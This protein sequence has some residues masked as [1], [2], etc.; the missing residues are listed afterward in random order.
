MIVPKARADQ[1]ANGAYINQE[2]PKAVGGIQYANEHVIPGKGARDP[3]GTRLYRFINV[4]GTGG[5]RRAGTPDE[6]ANGAWY[7][8]FE[9]FQKMKVYAERYDYP[10]GYAARLFAAVL[11][12]WSDVDCYVVSE[13]ISPKPIFAWKGRGRQIVAADLNDPNARPR[14]VRDQ[15]KMTPMQTQ[16]EVYQ[17]FIPGLGY[18]HNEYGKWFRLA[19]HEMVASGM[20]SYDGALERLVYA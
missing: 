14:D 15:K 3:Q 4:K 20:P 1:F 19:R 8:D 18:P 10:L 12:D 6:G 7:F 9:N 13:V 11:Y 2:R 16:W 5:G 17:L